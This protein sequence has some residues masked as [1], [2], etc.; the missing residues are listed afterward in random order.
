MSQDQWISLLLKA[1]LICGFSSIVAW[2]AVYTARARWWGSAIGR[3]LVAKSL[4]IAGLMV[5]FALRLF[6]HL[7]RR[8]SLA[9]GWAEVTLV[10][11]ITPVMWWRIAVWLRV[12]RGKGS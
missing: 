11:A 10:G 6:F 1:G 9:A 2:V 12:S 8:D 7:S 4:L 5:P 3:T